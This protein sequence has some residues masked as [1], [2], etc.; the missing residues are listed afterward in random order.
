VPAVT[1]AS[2]AASAR[3]GTG[4]HRAHGLL[5]A[6]P[7]LRDDA[8][9]VVAEAG[10]V[11]RGDELL[12]EV[13]D[14]AQGA[15]LVGADEGVGVARGAR[16]AGAADAVDVVLGVHGHVE[17]DDGIDAGDVDAAAHDVG[18]HEHLDLSVAE[19]LEAR[20]RAPSGC[21]RRA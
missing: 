20:A 16:A 7:L 14:L 3:T 18:R 15:D 10:Q 5:C 6:A 17:V 11:P 8:A 21:G 1:A 9:G 13:L 12:C 4:E 2:D 19:A